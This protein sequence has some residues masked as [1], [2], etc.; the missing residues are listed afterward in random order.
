MKSS[1]GFGQVGQASFEKGATGGRNSSLAVDN[2]ASKKQIYKSSKGFRV[3]LNSIDDKKQ[4]NGLKK[5]QSIASNIGASN[6]MTPS[7][8]KKRE[9]GEPKELFG[10]KVSM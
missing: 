6:L 5:T 1:N 4:S 10:R 2:M 3:I 7:G 8:H 9:E